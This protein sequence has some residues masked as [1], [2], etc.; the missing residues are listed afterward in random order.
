MARPVNGAVKADRFA[1]VEAPQQLGNASSTRPMSPAWQRAKR[2][3]DV[4]LAAIL[5]VV[6]SPLAL[7]AV[8]VPPRDDRRWQ[9]TGATR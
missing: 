2:V 6:L 3:I 1:V 9:V 8:A 4:L 7:I 5:L